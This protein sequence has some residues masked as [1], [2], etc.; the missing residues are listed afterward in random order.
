MQ[1]VI[2]HTKPQ[3]TEQNREHFRLFKYV[4]CSKI[5]NLENKFLGH[6][7][8]MCKPQQEQGTIFEDLK[9]SQILHISEMVN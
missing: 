3:E 2:Q 9:I 6:M 8:S 1:L 7:T 4:I 5:K